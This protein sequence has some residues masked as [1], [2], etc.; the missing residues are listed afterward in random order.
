M[1]NL[2]RVSFG[3]VGSK[4][5]LIFGGD[6]NGSMKGV[7]A[8]SPVPRW[9]TTPREGEFNL[10]AAPINKFHPPVFFIGGYEHATFPRRR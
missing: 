8:L 4:V 3:I 1:R 5:P 10:F 6:I 7:P 2:G 9:G